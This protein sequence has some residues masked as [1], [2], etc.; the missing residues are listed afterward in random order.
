MILSFHICNIIQLFTRAYLLSSTKC[1]ITYY[2]L[3][4]Y[5]FPHMHLLMPHLVS[6]LQMISVFSK[7]IFSK[8]CHINA[9]DFNLLWFYLE[10]LLNILLILIDSVQIIFD[11][12]YRNAV[13]ICVFLCN[14]YI[15]CFFFLSYCIGWCCQEKVNKS[16]RNVFYQI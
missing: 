2:L 1:F 5:T 4:S 8:W 9:I 7:S 3:I 11:F 16:E 12:L 14:F 6:L 10:T 13:G 15:T